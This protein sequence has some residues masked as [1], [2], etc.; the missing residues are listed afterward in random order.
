MFPALRISRENSNAYGIC[1]PRGIIFTRAGLTRSKRFRLQQR[2]RR[3]EMNGRQM[4]TAGVLMSSLALAACET[5]GPYSS[6]PYSSGP[7]SSGPY[8]SE[9]QY[10]PG[11]SGSPG[12]PSGAGFT[13]TVQSVEAIRQGGGSSGVGAVIGGVAGGLL[14]HQI[15]S[16]RGN[17]AATIGGAV[18]GAV[19]GNEIEKRRNVDETYRFSVRMDDGSVQT[20]TQDTPSLR[21]GDRVRNE[22]GRLVLL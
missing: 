7:Y 12:Y 21:V 17:T 11:Y 2:S 4:F 18:G 14:G 1:G 20:F 3:L 9:P 13:G 22:N 6:G 19:V 10:N 16:G 8:S 15:G 5:P